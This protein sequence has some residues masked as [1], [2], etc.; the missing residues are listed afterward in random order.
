MPNT[1]TGGLSAK[2]SRK[3][4]IDHKIKLNNLFKIDIGTQS[5]HIGYE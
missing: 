3:N 1:I 4:P 2:N 5:L